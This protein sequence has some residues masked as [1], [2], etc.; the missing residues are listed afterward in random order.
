VAPDDADRLYILGVPLLTS[1]DGGTTWS[2][3]NEPN[4]HVDHH[5]M[6]I[7]PASPDRLVLGNDGGFATSFDGG[8][9]WIVLNPVPVGQ[10]YSVTVD[11][12]DPYN[13]YGGL[14][15][16][17]VYK[18][19]SRTIPGV[20]G[21]WARIGGGDGMYV[22]VDPRDGTTY[23]GF[24][25]GY[26]TRKDPNGKR[27][28]VRP[29]NALKE[30]ALRYNWQT[31]VQLSSHNPDIVY[32]GAN[33]L[34]RSMDRGET[35]TAVS[36]DL[37]RSD[38]RGNVPFATITTID[39][40]ELV[41]GR[42]WAGT[43]D[44]LVWLTPDGGV[45]WRSVGDDLPDGR[46]VSRVEASHHEAERAYVSLNGYRDDDLAAYVYGTDD[47]GKNWRDLS[48]NLPD[49]PVNVVREDP[50]NPQVLY[51]GTDR[52][53]YVSLDRGGS[54]QALSGELPNVPV[55][56][57]VIHP[58][59]RELVAGTH[60]RSV[61]ILDVLP[62]QELDDDVRGSG[63]HVFPVEPVE[64]ERKWK[65]RRH[66]WWYKPV[67]DP[68]IDAP[69][70][71]EAAG[72]ATW[73]VL[74]DDGRTLRKETIEAVDGMNQLTWDLLLDP[75]LALPAERERLAAEE[76][77]EDDDAKQ[78][79]GGALPNLSETPWAEAVRLDRPLYATPGTYTLRVEIGETSSD[80]EIVVEA[81]EPREPRVKPKPKI[82]GQK[83]DD[84]RP[85]A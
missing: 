47:L 48:A 5:A 28:R 79:E 83:D 64:F 68:E 59:E 15:D 35:W 77:T 75:D 9:T 26:Y 19:S 11:D 49:E 43:D 70:W 8:N 7:D 10:F 54:W 73:S 56:D 36:D 81:P 76:A 42:I 82:R 80:T 22:Q 66:R 17:G 27:E 63:V 67:Y 2:N 74:D 60:G 84:D 30:P 51:A 14:Q 39:E 32:F 52:G 71:A 41:F 55:H 62:I 57:L 40:S 58:R 24:Q 85:D 46:W 16:N 29:R 33:K 13:V 31:P 23:F 44:G 3:I 20:Y 78:D 4:V 6:W 34:F 45:T 65:S 18:G 50:V 38:R 25:F 37:T 69:F 72:T 53:A 1:N 21:E 12:A 61:W